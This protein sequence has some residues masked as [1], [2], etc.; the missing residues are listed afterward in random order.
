MQAI[1]M[2]ND[3]KIKIKSNVIALVILF[4]LSVLPSTYATDNISIT[5]MHEGPPYWYG[6]GVLGESFLEGAS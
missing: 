1:I 3:M 4:S 2:K 6:K 5:Y